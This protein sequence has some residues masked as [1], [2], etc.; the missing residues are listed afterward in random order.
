MGTL[1][2]FLVTV[3]FGVTGAESSPVRQRRPLVRK[4]LPIL[5][6]TLPETSD[7]P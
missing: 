5:A 1:L 4:K 7:D 3:P 2:W 6:S